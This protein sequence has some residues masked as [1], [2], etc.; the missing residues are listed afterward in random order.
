MSTCPEEGQDWRQDSCEAAL[1]LI[2][3]GDDGSL[4]EGGGKREWRE[5]NSRDQ[6]TRGDRSRNSKED[7]C[8]G[9]SLTSLHHILLPQ[10]HA[11][12]GRLFFMLLHNSRF[13]DLPPELVELGSPV[14]ASVWFS[15]ALPSRDAYAD[16]SLRAITQH[17]A[18]STCVVYQA[19]HE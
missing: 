8:K 19:Q 2:C 11:P 7:G 13:L 15:T 16:E 9:S 12:C 5:V 3:A 4:K 14:Q 17:I 1:A 6:T 10:I 18:D